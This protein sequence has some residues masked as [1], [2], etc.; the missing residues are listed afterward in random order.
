MGSDPAGGG[1]RVAVQN[2]I[3]QPGA[4]ANID[5]RGAPLLGAPPP[6]PAEQ[7]L[8]Q[9]QGVHFADAIHIRL[10]QGRAVADDG[11]ADGVPVTPERAATSLTERPTRPT[12]IVTHRA[13]RSVIAPRG[14]AM[15]GFGM[16]PRPGRALR[17]G[18]TPAVLAPHQPGR[19]PEAGE[20]HELN[21]RSVLHPGRAAAGGLVIVARDHRSAARYPVGG[22]KGRC[23][24]WPSL[25]ASIRRPRHEGWGAASRAARPIHPSGSCLPGLLR[26]GGTAAWHGRC[27]G[28]GRER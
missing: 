3:E 11:V 16:G 20:I 13:A 15:R 4:G 24:D 12:W 22:A 8:V 21:G 14:T 28:T 23:R 7:C 6:G 1:R 10:E 5:D 17:P 27:A 2:D 26:P 18:T 9:A 19:T 25:W